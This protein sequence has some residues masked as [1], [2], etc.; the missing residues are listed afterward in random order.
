MLPDFRYHHIGIAVNDIDV[1]AAVYTAAGYIMTET[2]FDPLQNVHICFLKKKGMPMLELLAPEDETSPVFKILQKNGVTP[3]HFCYEVD[4][5][6]GAIKR[7]RKMRYVVVSKPLPAV[8]IDGRRVC[9]LF[10]RVVGL[11]EIVEK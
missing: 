4:D 11:I 10:N 8:A 2:V 6:D 9:F 7:L 3:Y 1:T 5:L